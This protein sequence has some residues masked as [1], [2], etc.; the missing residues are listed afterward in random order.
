[1]NNEAYIA[2]CIQLAKNGFGRV[3]PNPMVG[4]VIVHNGEIIGE[5]YHQNYGEAHAEVNAI[6]AV[7]DTS[8]LKEAT[9]FVSLEPCAHFGK[10]PPCAD[11]II[12]HQIPK[13]VIGCI[14]T[15][16]EVSG[17][18]IERLRSKNVD[19]TVGVLEKECIDL[20]K[21]F[22]TFH[23]KKRPYIILKWAQSKDGYM[24][25]LRTESSPKIN[26]ITQ[27]ETQQ[28]THLWRS[29]ENAIL[30]GKTTV[31]NDN[32]SLTVRAIEGRN[33]KRFVLAKK[34]EIP[35]DYAVCNNEVETHFIEAKTAQEICDVLYQHNIQS[36]IIEGGK[37]TL[38]TFISANIWDEARIL[39]G[40][41]L[42]NDGLKSPTLSQTPITKQSLGKDF[43]ETFINV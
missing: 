39:T 32:P 6:N 5:G 22:F 25:K 40:N 10:T 7:K 24:D 12:H 35:S 16:S 3:S 38:E 37:Q 34:E 18:G 20:N 4:C 11:L 1:M 21:R 29:Q 28:L 33:P 42:F 19:V 9:L 17:K 23:N 36:V 30:V 43:L 13:V 41:V 26:W 14:D 8:L 27:P 31:L 2:R 15:F